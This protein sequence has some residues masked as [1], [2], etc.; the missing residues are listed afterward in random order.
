MR[1]FWDTF[2]KRKGSFK[3]TKEHIY[4]SKTSYYLTS[5]LLFCWKINIG[6]H[7]LP[8]SELRTQNSEICLFKSFVLHKYEEDFIHLPPATDEGHLHPLT[9]FPICYN[10]IL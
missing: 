6:K 3:K 9:K 4:L 8:T 2:M 5:S 1:F 10:H 7:D